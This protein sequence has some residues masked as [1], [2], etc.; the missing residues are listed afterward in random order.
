MARS[1][2]QIE[3]RIAEIKRKTEDAQEFRTIATFAGSER[4]LAVL[5]RTRDF[6]V[7]GLQDLDE[8]NPALSREYAK[9]KACLKLVNTFIQGLTGAEQ[10]LEELRKQHV[11][12][13]AELQVAAEEQ[14]KRDHRSM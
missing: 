4:L 3:E 12:L 9:Q 8:S 2:N 6:Y 11:D 10:K 5:N 7:T 14:K 13:S 1:I